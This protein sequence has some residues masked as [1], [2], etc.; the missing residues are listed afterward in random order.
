M[1]NFPLLF[2]AEINWHTVFFYLTSFIACGFAL[3]MV[4]SSNVVRMAFFLVLSLAA[5]SGLI[6]LTGA[7]F[8]GAMQLMIYVGGT[9]VLLIF[10]VMLTAQQAF[11][12]MKT[13]AGDWILALIV[14][15]SLLAL[16]TQIAFSIPAWHASD[17]QARLQTEV[18]A[19][20]EEIIAA[21]AADNRTELTAAEEA[22]LRPLLA[23]VKY[24]QP[25][26]TSQIGLGL[27]GVR[28]D[29][30]ELDSPGYSGYLLPFE[31]VSVHLLVV[32]VGAAYLARSK[33]SAVSQATE[34]G[35][36]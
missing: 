25:E 28:V 1:I 35:D 2:A 21:M 34:G 22:K 6:F 15:G 33:R 26:L 36:R 7:H 31:I 19:A 13:K 11:I 8:V 5:T 30:P 27:V 9:V 20:E 24:G 29:K 4:V 17:Y 12:S 3:A 32:L 23:K 18:T 14:G 16:L 10:G